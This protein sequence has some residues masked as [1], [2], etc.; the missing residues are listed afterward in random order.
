MPCAKLWANALSAGLGAI[1]VAAP[2]SAQTPLRLSLHYDGRL[3]VKVLDVSIEQAVEAGGFSA[4]ARIRTSG[5]LALF[6]KLDLKAESRG[7]IDNAVVSPGVFFS[8]NTD[9]K[10][11]RAVTATWST[12]DVATQ[13]QPHYPDMGDP[14][15]SREQKLE[16]ADPLTVL[17]RMTLL[18]PGQSPC[19]GVGRFYDGKQRYDIDY[20]HRAVTS[21]DGRE[22]ALGLT[23]TL[24]CTLVYREVAGFRRKPVDQR[25]QGL[26][27]DVSLGLGRL[28]PSGP[29]LISFLRAETM[30]GPASIDLVKA[31]ATI[32]PPR[33]AG[34]AACAAQRE[35]P[36]HLVGN[37]N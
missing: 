20:T 8:L 18:P 23:E 2:A 33:C 34:E 6:R 17:T 26:R 27:H 22:R 10:K 13:S 3:L 7:R 30:F 19:Q 36:P 9:G 16:A 32:P 12:D 35:S 28:G 15:A 31:S 1:L 4:S 25:S 11:N 29:W 37:K 5:L 14:P 21:P 24:S